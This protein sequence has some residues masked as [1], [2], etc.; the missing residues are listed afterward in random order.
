MSLA[1]CRRAAAALSLALAACGGPPL[2]PDHG[3]YAPTVAAAPS[4]ARFAFPR[5]KRLAFAPPPEPFACALAAADA[6]LRARGVPMATATP[7]PAFDALKPARAGGA[8]DAER[9]SPAGVL[10]L[11][12]AIETLDGPGGHWNP[13]SGGI[14]ST[15]Q[16][17]DIRMALYEPGRAEPLWRAHARVRTLLTCDGPELRLQ[18]LQLLT[19][20][21]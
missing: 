21:H 18:L 9:A 7:V 10:V 14:A 20:I 11:A 1:S 2:R 15:H 4:I 6:D 5:D 12:I 17:T 16:R 19:Q 3:A 8:T 13:F